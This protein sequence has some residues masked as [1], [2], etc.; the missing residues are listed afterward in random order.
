LRSLTKDW[1]VEAAL[2]DAT[3]ML[4]EFTSRDDGLYLRKGH[5]FT[6]VYEPFWFFKGHKKKLIVNHTL[7]RV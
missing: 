6:I 3:R 1:Q 5:E 7:G 2:P 4:L